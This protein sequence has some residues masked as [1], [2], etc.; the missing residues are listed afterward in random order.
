VP[1]ALERILELL[2]ETKLIYSGIWQQKPL[3]CRPRP[4]ACCRPLARRDRHLVTRA[5]ETTRSGNDRALLGVR[6]EDPPGC[7]LERD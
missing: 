2:Q 6:H 7:H 5:R 4:E 1:L 3:L